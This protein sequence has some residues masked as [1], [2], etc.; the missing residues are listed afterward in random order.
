MEQARP[1]VSMRMWRVV[2]L[3]DGGEAASEAAMI[4]GAIAVRTGQIGRVDDDGT[5]DSDWGAITRC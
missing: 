5:E 4:G 2:D 3:G 1:T